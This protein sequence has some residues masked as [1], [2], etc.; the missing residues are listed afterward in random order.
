MHAAIM[1]HA[2]L[3]ACVA[4]IASTASLSRDSRT[5]LKH[6]A[7][8]TPAP[9]DRYMHTID[10][11][12]A[13]GNSK[14]DRHTI[15]DATVS[16][17]IR[18]LARD[19][20]RQETPSSANSTR[21]SEGTTVQNPPSEPELKQTEGVATDGTSINEPKNSG[22][23]NSTTDVSEAIASTPPASTDGEESSGQV[24][25]NVTKM[26]SIENEILNSNDTIFD[27]RLT[28]TQ[29]TIR[30]Q[31]T[32]PTSPTP[33][34]T[35]VATEEISRE[36]VTPTHIPDQNTPRPPQNTSLPS[37]S[38]PEMEL[39]L[40]QT[41]EILPGQDQTSGTQSPMEVVMTTD[42]PSTFQEMISMA[43]IVPKTG[44]VTQVAEEQATS[45]S[46]RKTVPEGLSNI[47]IHEDQTPTIEN[48]VSENVHRPFLNA[49]P[50][51]VLDDTQKPPTQTLIVA[52]DTLSTHDIVELITPFPVTRLSYASKNPAHIESDKESY[53]AQS[54]SYDEP[55]TPPPSESVHK[56]N[57]PSTDS[58]SFTTSIAKIT[59]ASSAKVSLT[60]LS[61]IDTENA[62]LFTTPPKA[63]SSIFDIVTTS[64]SPCA[65]HSNAS[66]DISLFDHV[67]FTRVSCP[68]DVAIF[69]KHTAIDSGLTA[70]L[71]ITIYK[72]LGLWYGMARL[73]DELSE[74]T[75]T[76][77][78]F[79]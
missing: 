63:H 40:T 23:D 33:R 37:M 17:A 5:P 9:S 39:I 28:P 25:N 10:R 79:V 64:P 62:S 77:A 75:Y 2:I 51:V 30:E 44:T 69:D 58:V 13:P 78:D 70:S 1:F 55:V 74:Y 32:H 53:S 4:G 15:G 14:S 29:E 38:N 72:R 48:V 65:Y 54:E 19:V 24:T 27:D 61:F 41:T 31:N 35:K 21:S 3:T 18:R 66:F 57:V 76:P 71:F 68:T 34:R 50:P 43:Q 26:N 56:D 20:A 36:R 45:E 7:I 16:T 11:I 8:V 22:A 49:T 60:P 59:H 46:I 67:T 6:V 47:M 73:I 42:Q 52:P 12:L